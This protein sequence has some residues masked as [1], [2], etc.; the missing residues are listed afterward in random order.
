MSKKIDATR[1]LY[2]VVG[3]TDL[4]VEYARKQTADVQ[5]RLSRIELEPKALGDQART[6]LVTRIDELGK[7]AKEAR[8]TVE[9]RAKE[10]R[11]QVETYVNEAVAEVTD[12]YGDL[13]VRGRKLVNRIRRQQAT[14]DAKAAAE[15][16][17]A[18]VKTTRTQ[19]TKSAKSTASTA[20]RATKSA[21]KS[22]ST[23]A[24]KTGETAKRNV[25]AT[26]TAAK[27]TAEASAKAAGDAAE[28]VGD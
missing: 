20:K 2:A 21:S 12:T 23:A 4:A 18:K 7:D 1:P 6:V 14:Q 13:A 28:K 22:T 19:T 15:T 16:T 9:A 8:E 24:K 25:K 26:T 17:V 10:A 27:K 11:T 5:A 3:A